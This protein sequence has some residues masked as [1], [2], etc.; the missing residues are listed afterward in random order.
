MAEVMVE[1]VGLARA[2]KGARP[3]MKVSGSIGLNVWNSLAVEVLA[4]EFSRLTLSPE[5]S[6]REVEELSAVAGS[7]PEPPDLEVLVQGNVEAMVAESCLLSSALGCHEAA[8][9]GDPFWGIEDET[10]RVF[11]VRADGECRTHIQ[12]A[13]ELSSWTSCRSSPD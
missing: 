10:G 4:P 12:N 13:V 11:P 2:V 7:I 3:E 8:T 1:G 5:L 9:S 6:A